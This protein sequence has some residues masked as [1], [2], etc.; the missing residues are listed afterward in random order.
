MKNTATEN[1]NKERIFI[2]S[3]GDSRKYKV[4]VKGAHRAD[5]LAPLV[6]AEKEL[7]SYLAKEFPAQSFTY[8]TTPKIQEI[9]P[10]HNRE[11]TSY[12]DFDDKAVAEVKEQLTREV[13]VMNQNRELNSN[14]PWGT[15]EAGISFHRETGI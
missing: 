15:G 3:F 6:K 12:P 5:A 1:K 14:D 7:N 13:K 2:V 9:D 8:Y 4:V 11:Y 10:A